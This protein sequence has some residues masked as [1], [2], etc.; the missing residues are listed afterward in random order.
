MLEYW[1]TAC[2]DG[3][4][5]ARVVVV[6]AMADIVQQSLRMKCGKPTLRLLRAPH[7]FYMMLLAK[8]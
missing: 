2:L 1:A 7:L 6:V 8:V 4:D 3:V 5:V